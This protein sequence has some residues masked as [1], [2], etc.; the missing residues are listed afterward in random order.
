MFIFEIIKSI[1]GKSN[2]VGAGKTWFATTAATLII[3]LGTNIYQ[4]YTKEKEIEAAVTDRVTTITAQL[5]SKIRSEVIAELTLA[6]K[7][8][9]EIS[10]RN[11]ADRIAATKT[12]SKVNN[13]IN[14]KVATRL[15]SDETIKSTPPVSDVI[16]DDI[17]NG[18]QQYYEALRANNTNR[19]NISSPP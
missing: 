10:S 12:S 9:G 14:I 3:S 7:R 1:F 16:I 17:S 13:D 8:R 5:E 18:L 11:A 6:D 19:D 15:K 4:N 2:K